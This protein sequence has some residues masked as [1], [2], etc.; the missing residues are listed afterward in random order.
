MVHPFTLLA[1]LMVSFL[2]GVI[3]T[4]AY[5]GIFWWLDRYKKAPI[6]LLS[7]A[8]FWGAIPAILISL[9]AELIFGLPFSALLDS[10]AAQVVGASAIAPVVEES[11]KGVSLL[12]LLLVFGRY[13]DDVLDGIIF[14]AVAGLGFAATEDFLY[15]LGAFAE[16][17]AVS[18][19]LVVVLR[20]VIFGL[21]H[22]FFTSIL[23]A[24][25]GQARLSPRWV[26]RLLLPLGGLTL[27]ISFHAVHNLAASFASVFCWSLLVGVASDWIG[28]F[29]IGV[30][31]FFV[32]RRQRR[33]I[34][35]EL[36]E[37]VSQGALSP[38]EYYVVSSAW[39]RF[40]ARWEA[41]AEQGWIAYSRL[42][43]L[44]QWLTELAFKKH[45]LKILGED[46]GILLE[47]TRLR[48]R[49]T[50]LRSEMGLGTRVDMPVVGAVVPPSARSLPALRVRAAVA[51]LTIA[52]GSQKGYQF[53]LERETTVIGRQK[54]DLLIDDPYVS[55]QHAEVWRS[56]DAY[57]VT[58]L[59]SK[60]GTF[61]NGERVDGPKPL[62]DGD[63]LG[64]GG[65]IL[66]FHFTPS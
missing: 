46:Q 59:K 16:G 57:Y 51:R 20:K 53:S 56:G 2:A 3:P 35:E 39:K 14:G 65:T 45:Q 49:V 31:I 55:R 32:L 25:L 24:S 12:F 43:K 48:A 26:I 40:K 17:G 4:A 10:F 64:I 28:I 23:G 66:A 60:N 19:S 61:L 36:A 5:I 63:N 9:I 54:G 11:V 50:R 8:F 41:L 52:T 34:V 21:N 7:I 13:F 18:F 33:W 6:W 29:A 47:I 42:G 30:M 22:A 15:F 44:Y 27:A 58:D 38:A 37:E 62:H 1:V